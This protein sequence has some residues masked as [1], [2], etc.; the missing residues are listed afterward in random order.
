MAQDILSY[1]RNKISTYEDDT[2]PVVEGKYHF[3][4]FRTLQQIELYTNSEYMYS[5]YDADGKEMGF[6]NI[7]N[8]MLSTAV[9]QEDLDTKDIALNNASRSKPMSAGYLLLLNKRFQDWLVT[10]QFGQ[11]LNKMI[12]TKIKYGGVLVKKVITE[13]GQL[14]ID[15]IDWRKS[16]TDPVDILNGGKIM[17]HYILP[18]KLIEYAK[19]KNW[20]MD[21]VN[22]LLDLFESEKDAKDNN[23]KPRYEG[24]AI[25]VYEVHDVFPKSFNNGTGDDHE[26][27]MKMYYVG[28]IESGKAIELFEQTYHEPLFKYLPHTEQSGRALGRGVVEQGF[29]SQKWINYFKHRERRLIDAATLGAMATDDPNLDTETLDEMSY[30]EI[31]QLSRGTSIT[32]IRFD[33]S[34]IPALSKAVAELLENFRNETHTHSMITGE[35]VPSGTPDI[36]AQRL[37][38]QAD[39]PFDKQRERM[40][41]FLDEIIREWVL[42]H[43]AKE[44]TEEHILEADFSAD[45][46]K[47]IDDSFIAYEL[48]REVSEFIKQHGVVPTDEEVQLLEQEIRQQQAMQGTRRTFHI[49]EG[50]FDNLDVRVRVIVTNEKQNQ[51][52][53]MNNLM[54]VLQ[55]LTS[56]PAILTDPNMNRT[57]NKIME[58]AGLP[59]VT[60]AQVQSAVEP[61]DEKA[62]VSEVGGTTK[63]T[64]LVVNNQG[65]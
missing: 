25:P 43:L 12:Y 24:G 8:A 28:G 58:L 61:V 44:I 2:I 51:Q 48:D 21:R 55:M 11:T 39:Q 30:N 26:Y 32:P 19:K 9:A 42:P 7:V 4:Q 38:K 56:N 20:N 14:K 22:E 57:F 54:Q 6:F 16:Y 15:V 37:Q 18:N 35:G 50:Y 29:Q 53:L 1:I 41:L 36:L 60:P 45:E 59:P 63:P 34:S 33:V 65:V 64:E 49:P 47:M 40:G 17:V 62:V 52:Q 13:D 27:E 3:S 46:L 10:S 31:L 5:K 23:G